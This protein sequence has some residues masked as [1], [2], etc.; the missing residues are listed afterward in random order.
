MLKL[1][2][3]NATTFSDAT[4]QKN[5]TYGYYVAA[6][7]SGKKSRWSNIVTVSTGST[8]A[9]QLSADTHPIPGRIEAEDYRE[10]KEGEAY[11]DTTRGNTGGAYRSD[12]V[13]IQKTGDTDGDYN[14]GWIAAGEWLSYDVQ[15]MNSGSYTII[16][17]VASAQKG[18]KRLHL[19]LNGEDITGP[20]SF[21]TG[22]RGWQRYQDVEISGV[23]LESGRYRLK[24]VM[25]TSAFNI[26]YLRFV[27][28]E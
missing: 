7:N 17:R 27:R 5:K 3:A 6:V 2:N 13:D 15:V 26:N 24:L 18:T 22:G 14:V 21:S 12:D 23:Q 28:E 1:V 10:G 19:E 9:A 25:D 4:V 20:V 16:F 8:N 11:H